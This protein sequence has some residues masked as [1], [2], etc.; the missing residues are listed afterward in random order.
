MLITTDMRI[1]KGKSLVATPSSFVVFDIETTGL[2]TRQNEIIEIGA[3]KV[4]DGA[5]IDKFST[6][7]KPKSPISSF[8]TNLTG[9]TNQMV[10]N[11]PQI[12]EVLTN[13]MDFVG[14][15]TLMGHNVNFDINF[16]YDKLLE[17]RL[18]PLTND[19][20][21]TLRLSRIVLTNLSHHKLSDLAD[22]YHIDKTGSHRSLKDVE[23]TLEV[24]N[25]LKPEIK[26]KMGV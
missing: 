24:Y 4:K 19:F 16:I 17:C 21:D 11:A 18:K 26:L 6:L 2:N 12:D 13:F 14:D 1:K 22:Y 3:L 8:I 15:N 10:R 9:I 23:M 7:I 5:I 20:V 25:R